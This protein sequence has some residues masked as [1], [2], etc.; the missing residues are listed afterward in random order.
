MV[1]RTVIT[2]E[3][4][5]TYIDH[6]PYRSAIRRRLAGLRYSAAVTNLRL[7]RKDALKELRTSRELDS[8]RVSLLPYGFGYAAVAIPGVRRLVKSPLMT[9]ARRRLA[10]ALGVMDT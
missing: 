4:A 7:S 6:E 5:L 9:R 8:G 2:L 3:K 10:R 1:N